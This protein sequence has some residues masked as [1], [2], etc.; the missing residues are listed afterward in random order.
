MSSS[1]DPGRRSTGN[2]GDPSSVYWVKL[3]ISR[4]MVLKRRTRSLGLAPVD[5]QSNEGR[6]P[7]T[8]TPTRRDDGVEVPRGHRLT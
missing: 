2:H 5:P 8:M 4:G 7:R 6:R 3:V 1:P